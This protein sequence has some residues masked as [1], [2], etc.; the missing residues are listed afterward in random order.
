MEA[1]N[2]AGGGRT[3]HGPK[4]EPEDKGGQRENASGE[5]PNRL[6]F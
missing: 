1:G 2:Q 3:E 5:I 6:F 4:L